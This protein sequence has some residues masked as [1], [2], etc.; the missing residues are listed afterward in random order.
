V[1]N[2]KAA[3][4]PLILVVDDVEGNR[5][6]V[7]R[8]LA[9]C[10]YESQPVESGTL[11]LDFI[12]NRKP[13]LVLLD[14]MMPGMSGIEGA[15]HPASGLADGGDPHHHADRARRTRCRGRGAGSGA[16]D[17]VTKPIDFDVLKARIETQLARCAIRSIARRQCR[18][19]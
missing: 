9:S 5:Q 2:H 7:C 17:Y 1:A 3:A 14:Y 8:R 18:A 13:D 12:R 4:A 16:D 15:A 10:G 6:L 11:A 19:G